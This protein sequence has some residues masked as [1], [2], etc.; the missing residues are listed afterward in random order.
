MTSAIAIQRTTAPRTRP[1]DGELGFG[2]HFTDHMFQMDYDP[3]RGWHAPRILP[4]GPLSV[5][6]SACGL[7]YGQTIFEGLKAF[8][9][10][11]G[12]VAVFRMNDHLARLNESARRLCIPPLDAK[13]LA[14]GIQALLELDAD[15]MPKGE[16]TSLY[17][18][19]MVFATEAFLGV[20]PS[21]TYTFLT[22]ISPVAN[23]YSAG[24]GPVRIWVE[25]KRIRAAPG[26]LGSAKTGANYAASLMAAEEAKARGYAQVLW[27]DATEHRWVEEVGTMNLFAVIG[28][29]VVTPPLDDTLLAG[30][31]RMSVL[32]L[33]RDWGVKVSERRVSIDELRAAQ[34][35]GTLREIFGTGTAAVIS[36]VGELGFE[37]GPM[38]I[39][40]G[41][42]GELSTR[43]R[44]EITGIQY[45]R[46]PDRFG[47]MSGVATLGQVA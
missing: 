17:L 22:F 36:P 19:P 34:A 8:P 3:E 39:G 33:L 26:G 1:G 5:D 6:P 11:D 13:V 24:A 28:D 10:K 25:Q 47:W 31:T 38:T 18:R 20:R 35:N 23:Y 16:G 42:V 44:A 40:D 37:E 27:L 21:K 30:V 14:Q 4:Y 43:L 45:G 29:E 9:D 41:S 12:N 15:W 2:R 46:V 32:A 7:H